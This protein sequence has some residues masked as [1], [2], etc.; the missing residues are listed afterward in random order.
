MSVAPA[1]TQEA[2]SNKMPETAGRV[3]ES[4]R[5]EV[6]DAVHAVHANRDAW[7]AVELDERIALI[8]KLR[9]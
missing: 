7:V 2:G 4:T 6:D 9:K 3:P 8:Q 1:M 5:A